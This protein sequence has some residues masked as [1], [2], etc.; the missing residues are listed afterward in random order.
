MRD[1][2]RYKKNMERLRT[3]TL[4]S[5]NI[6]NATYDYQATVFCHFIIIHGSSRH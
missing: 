6:E 4:R 5:R 2:Y 3:R 1:S